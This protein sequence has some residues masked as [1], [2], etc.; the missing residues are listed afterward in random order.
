MSTLPFKPSEQTPYPC[1]LPT[2]FATSFAY[3]GLVMD[4]Q[5]FGVSI[6][7][8]QVIFAAV[9]LPA[10]LVCF[11]VIKSLGRRPAQ[12]ASLLLAGICI[13]VNG[14]VPQGEHS[15]ARGCFLGVIAR[16]DSTSHKG[17]EPIAPTSKILLTP[18][19]SLQINPLSE[20]PS[21]C[22]GRAAWLLPSIAS[23]CT[24]GSCTP[25]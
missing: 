12:M 21:L 8:V 24:L 3:Y 22:W 6:Y 15:P 20:P 5:G 11:L 13:L 16:P 25:Q 9:D 1:S 4:L 14:V 23:F 10:K 2:R 19:L 7:L 18:F 17:G